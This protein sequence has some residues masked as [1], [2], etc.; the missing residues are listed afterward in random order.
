MEYNNG[1]NWITNKTRCIDI[2]YSLSISFKGQS[3]FPYNNIIK[4]AHYFTSVT[5]SQFMGQ[6]VAYV[7]GILKATCMQNFSLI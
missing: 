7:I 6:K 4:R 3:H 5:E 1:I 2:V